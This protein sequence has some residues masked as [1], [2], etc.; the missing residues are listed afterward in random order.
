MKSDLQSPVR[1]D[2][3]T[4]DQRSTQMG[5]V[6]SKNTKPELAVRSLVH[7]LGYR[8]RLHA[9]KLPGKPDLVFAARKKV[10]FVHGCYWHRHEGCARCRL[11]KTNLE[12]WKPKLETNKER[13]LRNQVILTDLGW[14]FLI[15]WECQVVKRE[16]GRL[17]D[18]ISRFLGP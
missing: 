12:F 14:E 7:S 15:V 6:Q 5:R 4:S 16:L 13:D 8:Y 9:S 18:R 10:I 1:L 3:L 11:P 17:K 2:P